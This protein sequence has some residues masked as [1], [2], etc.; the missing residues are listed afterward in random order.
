MAVRGVPT[1]FRTCALVC[2]VLSACVVI[3]ACGTGSSSSAPPPPS[4]PGSLVVNV[5]GVPAGA[6]ASVV[7]TG[8]GGF[9]QTIAQTT[10]L[11]NLTPGIYSFAAPILPPTS[12][13]SL[14]VPTYSPN[15]VTVSAGS[16]ATG[17]VAYGSLPLK[18][19]A[20]GPKA[21]QTTD[22]ALHGQAGAG[23]IG[24]IAVV[25]ANPPMTIYAGCA[26][27]FGPTSATGVYKTTNGGITW[28]PS[29]AGLTDPLVA[30][31]WVDQSNPNIVVA[32]TT[33]TGLFRSTDAGTTWQQAATP[34]FGQTIALLQV[35]TALYAGTSQGIVVSQDDGATW[36]LEEPTTAPVTSLAASGTYIYA[37]VNYPSGTVMVQS[38]PVGPWVTGPQ[39]LF[40]GMY[41]VSADPANPLHAI[42]AA[43]G[44]YSTPDV[45]E[46]TDGGVTW[47]SANVISLSNQWAIQ[48]LAYDPS[49]PT[50]NTVYAGADY[51]FAS[52][53]DGG[54]T[55]TQMVETGDVRVI[56][57]QFAGIKGMTVIGD[58]QG[59]FSSMDGGNTWTGMNGNLTT[60]LAYNVSV[61]GKTIVLA[62]QDYDPVSSFDGGAT[63]LS[64]T[65]QSANPA[66]GEFGTVLINPVN[67]QYVYAYSDWGFWLSAD[68]GMNYQL[69]TKYLTWPAYTGQPQTI[70][71]DPQSA[72]N[73]YVAAQIANG[74]L[75]GIYEST[76]YGVDWNLKWPTPQPQTPT[77]IAFDPTNDQNIFIGQA[78]LTQCGVTPPN[79]PCQ[80]G[81][82]QVSHD[83]GKTWTTV[84]LGTANDYSGWPVALTVNPALPN[85]VLIGMS[86]SPQAGGGAWRSTDGGSTFSPVNTGLGGNLLVGPEPSFQDPLFSLAYDPAGSGLVVAG[87][88][89]DGV[90]L[91]SDNGSNWVSAQ[92]NIL[93]IS[94]A[95][96]IWANG[97]IYATTFGQG[98]VQL[99][100][101]T[102][103]AQH[104]RRKR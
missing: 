8:P 80:V 10:T 78:D 51:Q 25:N 71:V 61:S 28:A 44:Y 58:D 104:A 64:G 96:A 12:T 100:V 49:D 70:A 34:N 35:G 47:Q 22:A 14:T 55:W 91:S 73:V 29:S 66:Y 63:W 79:Y 38:T 31:L 98:V 76:N 54:V 15:P 68:G 39:L 57:P 92:G 74:V 41:P 90:Y 18:W 56:V 81:S 102:R 42:V 50:G 67:P 46:T 26:G 4:G 9:S 65:A 88:G 99:P 27:W 1:T 52:S 24:A 97:S 7:V 43:Q 45:W 5:T 21:I 6:T 93:P 85:I 75:A 20:I 19:Q 36:T 13:S 2:A 94:T 86:G 62:M 60:S 87:L 101:T 95:S 40:Y 23:Q 53:N 16:T 77:L 3:T 89:W 37:A 11:T 84:T 48:Y 72:A 69:S 17:T 30:A 33:I 103:S 82:L 83:G 59:I 32:G